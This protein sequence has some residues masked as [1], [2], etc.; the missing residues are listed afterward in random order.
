MN[1]EI[2]NKLFEQRKKNNF[3]QEELAEK[4]GV[5]RQ[6]VS[7]W[8]RAEASPDTDNLI[9]LANLY[10]ISIDDLLATSEPVVSNLNSADMERQANMKMENKEEV[11]QEKTIWQI[12][13]YPLLAT[14]VYLLIGFFS[15]YWHPG[16][17]V[18]LTIPVYYAMVEWH[19]NKTK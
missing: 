10:G 15:G 2:A 3:S 11:K 6:A 12:L 9:L 14:I 17:L 16:W 7:K 19:A 4:I 5:S 18:F 8:E 1:I 13:P